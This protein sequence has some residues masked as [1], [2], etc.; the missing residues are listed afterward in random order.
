MR[1]PENGRVLSDYDYEKLVEA[2]NK[3]RTAMLATMARV[4]E[5]LVADGRTTG[6]QIHAGWKDINSY[7]PLP[8]ANPEEDKKVL[9][10][11]LSPIP[12]NKRKL[13]ITIRELNCALWEEEIKIVSYGAEHQSVTRIILESTLIPNRRASIIDRLRRELPLPKA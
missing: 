2:K 9:H 10:V 7:F 3:R 5:A 11:Q 8:P 12:D 1:P 13:R 4:N 6:A